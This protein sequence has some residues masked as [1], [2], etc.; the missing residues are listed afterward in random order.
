MS[1]TPTVPS[2]S[3]TNFFSRTALA[4]ICF[5]C[6]WYVITHARIAARVLH[7]CSDELVVDFS[8]DAIAT[9]NAELVHCIVSGCAARPCV[10]CEVS[11]FCAEMWRKFDVH[12]HD[13]RQGNMIEV[14]SAINEVRVTG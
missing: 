9:L 12:G 3:Y 14:A 13:E 11:L 4:C 1:E 10:Q 8:I 7:S 2:D 5:C 6:F